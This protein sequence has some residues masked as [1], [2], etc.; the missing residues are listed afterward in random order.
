MQIH[1]IVTRFEQ[2]GAVIIVNIGQ[3]KAVRSAE[4]IEE[5]KTIIEEMPQKSVVTLQTNPV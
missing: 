2:S 4:C 3:P 1:R 5:V